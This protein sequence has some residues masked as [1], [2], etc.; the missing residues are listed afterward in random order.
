MKRKMVWLILTVLVVTALVLTSCGPAAVEEEGKRV[1]GKVVEKEA[2]KEEKG[3]EVTPTVEGPQYGGTTTFILEDPQSVEK[4]DPFIHPI[5]ATTA[6]TYDLLAMGDY[7]RGPAGTNEF[8]FEANTVPQD[9]W[10][11]CLAESW[12]VP[13]LQTLIMHIRKGVRFQNVPPVNGR[14]LTAE[15]VVYTIE[16]GFSDPRFSYYFKPGTPEDKKPKVSNPDKW[17]VRLDWHEPLIGLPGSMTILCIV[18]HEVADLYENFNDPKHQ[19]GTGPFIVVDAVSGSSVT[20]RRNPDYWMYDPF[21]PANRL[22]YVDAAVGLIIPDESTQLAALRTHKVD[23]LFVPWDQ[24]ETMKKT[25]PELLSARAVTPSSSVI[26]MRTDLEPFNDKRV[27]QALALA[28]DQPAIA[29]DYYLGD[30][31]V[32][33]WP[34]QPGPLEYTPLE[35][36]PDECRELYEYHPDKAKTLLAE[37]GYPNGFKVELTTYAHPRFTDVAAILKEQLAKV[38]VDIEI[39]PL[40]MGAYWSAVF[41]KSYPAMTHVQ[42]ANSGAAAAF[43]WA[44]GGKPGGQTSIYNYSKVV[45][46]YVAEL[47]KTYNVTEDPDERTRMLKEENLREIELCWEIPLP[48]PATY[49]FWAPWLKGYHGELTFMQ[50]R[51]A[52]TN[53]VYRYVWIDRDLKYEIT[54]QRD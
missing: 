40:E 50:W 27:R 34:I 49:I 10:I 37:A 2:P 54:G 47:W 38:G 30:A 32:C 46:D 6:L 45:D 41:G 1:T 7:S 3:E 24:A 19:V 53:F 43:G 26:F 35:E 28:I 42:W 18:P 21:R 52:G 4:L 8:T 5:Q 33:T 25:N 39:R 20:W 17:T 36:M 44:H 29:K 15:D 13:D 51:A 14:E 22:P 31:Y 23:R 9:Y 48:A 16:R 12:E 11:G